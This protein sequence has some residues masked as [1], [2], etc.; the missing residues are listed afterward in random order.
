MSVGSIHGVLVEPQKPCV[1][2]RYGLLFTF[3]GARRKPY[4][5]VTGAE[6]LS[7]TVVYANRPSST[8]CHGP[9]DVPNQS[10]C[11]TSSAKSASNGASLRF[12]SDQSSVKSQ[13]GAARCGAIACTLASN[14]AVSAMCCVRKPSPSCTGRRAPRAVVEV[15]RDE[16]PSTGISRRTPPRPP[17]SPRP[18][19]FDRVEEAAA[20]GALI[21]AATAARPHERRDRAAA[22][23][24]ARA[25]AAAVAH[26]HLV[27][28]ERELDRS[29][30]APPA[31][32][33]RARAA[34]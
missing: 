34:T 25:V 10:A 32:D 27:V 2:V 24:P 1:R 20:V 19:S 30:D 18:S 11:H 21:R 23:V 7:V 4:G 6:R 28:V 26:V 5:D 22:D 33:E 9:L 17:R 3:H 16:G 31:R 29:L 15:E 14:S 12:A 8:V 13:Y